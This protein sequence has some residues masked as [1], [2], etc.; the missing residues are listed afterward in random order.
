MDDAPDKEKRRHTAAFAGNGSA[1]SFSGCFVLVDPL[2]E[3]RVQ[4]R[5]HLPETVRDLDELVELTVGNLLVRVAD[6]L[7]QS[8]AEQV[9]HRAARAG[10]LSGS[11]DRFQVFRG[12][13]I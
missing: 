9:H 6:V 4:G 11:P 8:L 2:L 5:F 1:G 3:D 10:R 13:E 12:K 7:D